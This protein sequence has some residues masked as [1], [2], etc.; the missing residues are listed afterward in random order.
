M[1]AKKYIF[2]ASNNPSNQELHCLWAKLTDKAHVD[3]HAEN[4]RIEAI[5]RVIHVITDR[6]FEVNSTILLETNQFQ[7]LRVAPQ[8]AFKLEAGEFAKIQGEIAYSVHLRETGKDECPVDA[9]GRV[10]PHLRD[11]FFAYLEKATGLAVQATDVGLC[12]FAWESR[13]DHSGPKK[14]W[15][16]DIITFT[17]TGEVVDPDQV[18][19]LAMRAIGRRKSYGLGS[20]KVLSSAGLDEQEAV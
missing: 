8:E 4:F 15:L 19:S 10:K 2:R 13:C 12:A 3:Q 18:N 7:L 16:N 20:V 9:F 11:R 17:V 6:E 14:V 5:G 1:T